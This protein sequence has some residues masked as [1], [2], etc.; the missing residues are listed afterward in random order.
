[1]S[2]ERSTRLTFVRNICRS[3]QSPLSLTQFVPAQTCISRHV[4]RMRNGLDDRD[5]EHAECR[6]FAD[7]TAITPF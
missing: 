5:C 7:F 1:L 6:A 4:M 2:A 3:D